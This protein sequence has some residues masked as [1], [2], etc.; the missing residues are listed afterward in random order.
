MSETTIGSIPSVR[1]SS[2]RVSHI[3]TS[4]HLFI[5]KMDT[6]IIKRRADNN[7]RFVDVLVTMATKIIN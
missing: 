6:A 2:R 3:Y 1:H 4:I 7:K 5:N